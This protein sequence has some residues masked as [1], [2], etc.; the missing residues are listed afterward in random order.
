[1]D[2]V[3]YLNDINND[4]VHNKNIYK[5]IDNKIH[6]FYAI[7]YNFPK[8][9]KDLQQMKTRDGIRLSLKITGLNNVKAITKS[10]S[11]SVCEHCHIYKDIT[12]ITITFPH[13][14]ICDECYNKIPN[15]ACDFY[16]LNDCY[17]NKYEDNVHIEGILSRNKKLI[18]FYS[19]FKYN[20]Y[21]DYVQLLKQPWYLIENQNICQWCKNDTIYLLGSCN[22]CYNFILNNFYSTVWI[23][24][25]YFK[26]LLLHE[27]I[28]CN[29]IQNI[30][31]NFFCELITI[32]I[33]LL[34]EEKQIVN[35]IDNKPDLKIIKPKVTED[36]VYD[37]YER[38]IDNEYSDD[39]EELINYND[40]EL[41]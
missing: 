18:H 10:K 40:D 39:D 11:I 20:Q 36:D 17:S 19:I 26:W 3:E 32:D 38:L 25:D 22:Q 9:V 15:Q 4:V 21:F 24:W 33:K 13:M 41:S 12:Q 29:D 30:I 23:K 14:L 28:L 37:Y 16:L 35:I 7:I 31:F 8:S 2:I 5:I 1:M 6:I 27:E 34:K